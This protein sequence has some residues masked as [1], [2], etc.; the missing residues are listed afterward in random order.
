MMF[1][2]AVI[3]AGTRGKRPR[4]YLRLSELRRQQRPG[5]GRWRVLPG[6]VDGMITGMGI[7]SVSHP[8]MILA[9]V[10]GASIL[11]HRYRPTLRCSESRL[12]CLNCLH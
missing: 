12:S 10:D 7:G 2:S 11:Q 3:P 5:T 4:W 1:A 8:T 9:F 6:H